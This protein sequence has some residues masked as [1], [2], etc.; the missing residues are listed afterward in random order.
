MSRS[1]H[2]TLLSIGLSYFCINTVTA[3][4]QYLETVKVIDNIYVFKPKLDYQHGNGVAIIGPTG[5]FFVDTYISPHYALEAIAK[6]KAITPHPVTFVLNTHWHYDHCIGN[7]EFKL[8]FPDCK[9]LMH[10]STDHFM[11]TN[12]KA[13]IATDLETSKQGIAD[14]ERQLNERKTPNGHP[15]TGSMIPY[16]EQTLR[17]GKEQMANYR[18]V[19]EVPADI[20][21]SNQITIPWGRFTLVIKQVGKNAHSEG[22][23]VVWIPETRLLISGDLIAGPVPYETNGNPW[24]MVEAIQQIIDMNP[25]IVIPGHGIVHHDLAYVRL[26][27]DAYEAYLR[28]AEKAVIN[29]I[30]L[31]EAV[32]YIKLDDLDF[33]FTHDDD[34]HKWAFRSFFK[35]QIIYRVYQKMGALPKR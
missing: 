14:T 29:K 20:S 30:P 6:L 21:I 7:Y 12:V 23:L 19:K 26:V 28:E 3:Q 9:F 33:K 24:G 22:D 27:K 10:D 35:G 18:P 11:R 31:K 25:S 17:E 34:L 13:L 16:W 2:A 32:A 5:V 1:I 8:A 15:M 4:G